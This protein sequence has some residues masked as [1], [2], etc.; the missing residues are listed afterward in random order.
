MKIRMAITV[1]AAI[2][3]SLPIAAQQE[4]K[5]LPT[6]EVKAPKDVVAVKAVSDALGAFSQSVTACAEKGTKPEVCQCR[7]PLH[8]AAL[9]K[10]YADLITLHP[11]WKDQLLSYQ[12]VDKEGRNVSGTL[13]LQTLRRQLDVLK[14]E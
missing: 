7:D 9:R 8:L 12:T 4:M 6:I 2:C 5:P 14:C 11:A 13:V 1:V 10:G 3:A